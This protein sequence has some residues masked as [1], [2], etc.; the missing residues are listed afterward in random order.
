M[1]II[2]VLEYIKKTMVILSLKTGLTNVWYFSDLNEEKRSTD[3][4]VAFE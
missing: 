4:S 1:A 2:S 3:G